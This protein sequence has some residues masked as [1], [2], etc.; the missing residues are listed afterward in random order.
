MTKEQSI[1]SYQ[2]QFAAFEKT[3]NGE[4]GSSFHALRREALLQ[5]AETGFP[6]L[7]N[8]DWR[9]TNL[10]PLTG[11]AFAMAIQPAESAML[12][13]QAKAHALRIPDAL[14]LLFVDGH[15]LPRLSDLGSLPE[16]LEVRDLPAVLREDA[17]PVGSA[18]TDA[19]V[20]RN[21]PFTALNT[22][23]TRQ[24]VTL[25]VRRNA[26]IEQPLHLL[27]FSTPAATPFVAHPRVVID[28]E[29]N[30]Q[31]SFVEQYVGDPGAVYFNNVVTDVHVGENAVVQHIKIQ[32]ES[33]A[34]FHVAANYATVARS[35]HY[36]N[37]YIGL[38]GALLRNAIHAVLAGEG[39]HCTM[40]GVYIPGG[41]QHM[42]HFTVTDHAVPNCTS[43]ELYKGILT[44]ETRGV[45]TG[46]II[47]R[48][49]AQKTD[50]RQANNNLLLSENAQIDTRPQLEIYAD[51][52]K[53]THG[54]TVGRIND[55]QL[56]YLESRGIDRAQAGNILSYAFASD[57]VTRIPLASLREAIDDRLYRRLEESWK[58]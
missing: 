42:D 18:A 26:L 56:F 40:N 25:S 44:D 23:F 51:D 19:T 15:F 35:G 3:L 7:R 49:D 14:T 47:V 32:D 9:Y 31:C 11:T 50:A 28:V 39:A 41:V 24:G 33:T 57:I 55:D 46:K 45:F 34:A 17:L 36:A 30:A 53:C 16:G 4:S 37:H 2:E 22:A 5:F 6:T 29:A 52:V 21:N 54:A 20:M 43:H 1:H 8:E 58:K 27:F 12:R 38:G 10:N 48:Q 13:S